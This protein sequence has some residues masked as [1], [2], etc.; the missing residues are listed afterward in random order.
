MKYKNRKQFL[1]CIKKDLQEVEDSNLFDTEWTALVKNLKQDCEHAKI[2]YLQVK[3]I[4]QLATGSGA[5]YNDNHIT[6]EKR[7]RDVND[8]EANTKKRNLINVD[9]S[10]DKTTPRK[11]SNNEENNISSNDDLNETI[12]FEYDELRELEQQIISSSLS[13]IYNNPFIKVIFGGEYTPYSLE[14]NKNVG[15]KQRPDFSCVVDNIAIL[16]SEIK[17]LGY[18]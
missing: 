9:S 2:G 10:D 6:L 8:K 14:I 13:E 16:N 1:D 15:G 18:T 7:C 5:T 12:E 4:N 17:P 11:C 3:Q